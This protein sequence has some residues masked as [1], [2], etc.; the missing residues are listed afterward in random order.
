MPTEKYDTPALLADS[1]PRAIY[2][3][4]RAADTRGNTGNHSR[5]RR[6]HGNTSNHSPSRRAH[7]YTGNHPS[8]R[9]AHGGDSP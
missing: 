8:S 9:R 2:A 3:D 1:S 4:A 6:A 5:S 7:G